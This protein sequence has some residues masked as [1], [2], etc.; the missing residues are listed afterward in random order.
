M[1]GDKIE[2]SKVNEQAYKDNFDLIQWRKPEDQEEI[3]KEKVA[4]TK[5]HVTAGICGEIGMS[6][7]DEEAYKENYDR[8]DWSKKSD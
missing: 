4:R 8:I 6:T 3:D 1:P 7:F 5:R 2:I